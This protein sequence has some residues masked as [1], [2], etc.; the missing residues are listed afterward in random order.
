MNGF[1]VHVFCVGLSSYSSMPI[2]LKLYRCWGQ[3]LRINIS[4]GHNPQICSS[5]FSQVDLSHFTAKV[6]EFKAFCL[7]NSSYI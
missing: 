1:M 5:L 6:N 4:P 7:G 3:V 2:H